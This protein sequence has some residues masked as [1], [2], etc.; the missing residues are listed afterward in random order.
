[1]Q[2]MAMKIP[3]SMT[4]ELGAW[5]GGSGIDLE[6]WVGCEGNFRLAVGYST[7]FWPRFESVGKYILVKGCTKDQIRGFEDQ[8]NATSKSV[9]TVLNHL[10]LEDIQ[11]LGCADLSSD[12]L[13]ILG[14]TLKEIYEAKLSWQFPDK[15]CV[16]EFYV[17]EDPDDF[18]GYQITFWQKKHDV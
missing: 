15:P 2:A 6:G 5:N 12:K 18:T 17:P 3:E 1:M 14:N 13:I 16:V 10:H 9:E 8:E 7:V 4:E 11:H